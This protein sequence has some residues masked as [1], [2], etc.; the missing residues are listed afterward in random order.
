MNMAKKRLI[1]L[2]L[3]CLVSVGVSGCV[4][5]IVGAVVDTTVEVVKIPFKVGGA[6]IDVVTPDES[7]DQLDQQGEMTKSA[8]HQA[9]AIR[10]ENEAL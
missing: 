6:I 2:L 3:L 5:T 7:A 1:T 9:A 10:M 8:D 4:G